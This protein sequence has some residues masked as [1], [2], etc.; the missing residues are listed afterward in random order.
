M[1]LGAVGKQYA[2]IEN[3]PFV[4]GEIILRLVIQG[5]WYRLIFSFDNARFTE[6]KVTLPVIKVQGGQPVFVFTVVTDSPVVQ[7]SGDYCDN[8]LP[9]AARK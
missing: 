7:F 8:R 5:A 1:N 3:D 6:G 4:D 9:T 2:V